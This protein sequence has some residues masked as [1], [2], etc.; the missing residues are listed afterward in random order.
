MKVSSGYRSALLFK[1][2]PKRKSIWTI[3]KASQLF[4][5]QRMIS[6]Y[7]CQV[8]KMRTLWTLLLYR[9]KMVWNQSLRVKV[10][11]VN[12]Q[13]MKNNLWKTQ[14][15]NTQIVHFD[16]ILSLKLCMKRKHRIKCLKSHLVS[17]L[18]SKQ[19]NYPS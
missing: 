10:D 3:M 9:Y 16:A 2:L 4:I 5:N 18:Y 7:T 1:K 14:I 15:R 12:Q 11:L 17:H 6:K 8:L 19:W 13:S